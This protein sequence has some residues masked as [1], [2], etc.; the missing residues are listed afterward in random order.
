MPRS[1][2]VRTLACTALFA[3]PLALA[4]SHSLQAQAASGGAPVVDVKTLAEIHVAITAVNDSADAR[5]AQAKNKTGEAQHELAVKKRELIAE[6]LKARGLTDSAYQRQRFMVSTDVELRAQFDS[7]VAKM[8]GAPLPGRVAAPVAPGFV[9]ASALPPGMVGT[10]IGHVT[11]SFVD[12]PE[13]VGL[14]P[15]AFSEAQVASQHAA[16]ATR[17]TSDLAAMKL[18]AGHVLHAV[19]PTVVTT[20]PGKGF[21]VKRAALGV[22][23]HIELAAKEPGASP[24]VK[25][26][27]TH[28]ATAARSTAAR[29]D[30]VVALAKKIQE[31]NDVKEAA[32]LTGQLA[33]L[34]SQLAAGADTNADGRIDWGNGEGG[35]QQAQEHITL[36]LAGE[37][38]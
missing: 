25:I 27:T 8:T 38:K 20:G 10:H 6:V 22:A 5:Q 2:L 36:L 23:Q 34:A 11:T 14:L 30:Q 24:N 33:S 12:T 18:H 32:T 3:A 28:I 9:A 1:S 26:H 37:K 21:G 19:D 4:P 16:L 31:T 35:L 7:L 13:K 15:L 29:V 17:A